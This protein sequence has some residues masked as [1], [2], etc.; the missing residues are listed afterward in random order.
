MIDEILNLIKSG[1]KLG[2]ALDTA[3]VSANHPA[4]SKTAG[5]KDADHLNLSRCYRHLR[6]YHPLSL[7][8]I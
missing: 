8:F 4:E 1:R 7:K 2:R 5:N 6:L 3:S